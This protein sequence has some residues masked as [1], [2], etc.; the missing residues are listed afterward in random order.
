MSAYKCLNELFVEKRPRLCPDTLVHQG[1]DLACDQRQR[2]KL[3]LV[4]VTR[5]QEKQ[6]K[7]SYRYTKE[8]LGVW[9]SRRPYRHGWL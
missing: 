5:G 2:H 4:T 8:P 9:S 6:R 3:S 7:P 1:K